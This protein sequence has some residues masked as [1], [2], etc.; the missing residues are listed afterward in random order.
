VPEI[1]FAQPSHLVSA[2][3]DEVRAP[4]GSI[5]PHWRPAHE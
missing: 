3:F 5:R 2:R 4:D 1:S